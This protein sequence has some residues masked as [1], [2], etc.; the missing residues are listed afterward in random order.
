MT[1]EVSCGGD[2]NNTVLYVED[3]EDNIRL[4]ERLLNRRRPGIA[5]IVATNGQDGLRMAEDA[6]PSLILLDRR[7]PDM[8]GN[9]VLRRLKAAT[10]TAAIPVVMLSGDSAEEQAA[11]TLR[12]GAVDFLP[13]P[14]EFAQ[15]LTVIDRFSDQEPL[16][17]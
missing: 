16:D 12:L 6:T 14:F 1:S 9:E 8:L 11:E 4:V 2:M 10:G 17:A 13:K 5:L 3:N 7:L 15:L